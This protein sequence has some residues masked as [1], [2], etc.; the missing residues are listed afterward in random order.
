MSF[1]D[2]IPEVSRHATSEGY[3]IHG[4]AEGETVVRLWNPWFAHGT[5]IA[6]YNHLNP[7]WCCIHR[8]TVVDPCTC[9]PTIPKVI[10]FRSLPKI[11]FARY[12]KCYRREIAKRLIRK[13]EAEA[14]EDKA[15]A[16]S[17]T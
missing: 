3:L 14:A 5:A 6:A 17:N 16:N 1:L 4:I 13:F 10:W 9:L 15:Q 8:V 2:D 7:T 11:D 12:A